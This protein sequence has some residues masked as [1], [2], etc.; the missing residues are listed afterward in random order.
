M[1]AT[2]LSRKVA[3]KN[4]QKEFSQGSVRSI[5]VRTNQNTKVLVRFFKT[6]RK[7]KLPSILYFPLISAF[8]VMTNVER[9]SLLAIK[10]IIALWADLGGGKIPG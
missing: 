6:Y 8:L 9:L 4:F 5:I 1:R 2:F 7:P 10:Y 3:P